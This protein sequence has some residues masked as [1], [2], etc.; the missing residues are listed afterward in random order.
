[1]IVV[2]L[3]RTD[4]KRAAALVARAFFA[5]PSLIA[6][7]PDEKSRA[8]K[9]PWYMEHVLKSAI[10]YGEVLTTDNL[11]GV[12]FLLPPGHTR[13]SDVD[14]IKSGFLA[15]PLVVGLKQYQ[16]V[17]VS[18]TYLADT[19][20]RLLKGRPHY[21]LWGIAVDPEQQRGGVGKALLHALYAKAD[22]EGMPIYLETHNP[23]N[24]AYYEHLGFCLIHTD[25]VP[26]DGMPF[27]CMLRE[28]SGA[29]ESELD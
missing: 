15:A 19:Q 24:V 25:N 9:L 23:D 16:T 29:E 3:K 22:R 6:Y 17:N 12:L 10:A 1:M 21:Y 18:E 13:L 27:W 5:Y 8:W 11:S 14:Y 26:A 28:P 20:E 7:F 4:R 2:P